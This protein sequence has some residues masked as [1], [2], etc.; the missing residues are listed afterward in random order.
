M[1]LRQR[2]EREIY[3]TEVEAYVFDEYYDIV[4]AGLG[5]AGCIA[6]I[7]AAKKGL[8]VLGIERLNCMGGQGTAGAVFSYYYGANG[9]LFEDIDNEVNEMEKL[10]YTKTHGINPFLKKYILEK[11]ALN[12][13]VTISYESVVTGVYLEGKKATG[14]KW[15]YDGRFI[16]TGAKVVIDSTA[17]ADI[18]DMAG[19]ETR[20]GREIDNGCQP[21]SNVMVTL[22]GNET[23]CRFIDEG[24]I[25]Q[26]DGDELSEAI[27][28]TMTHP[29][30]L[31]EYF[32]PIDR[33]LYYTEHLGVR[34]GRHIVG[35]ETVT[36]NDFLKDRVT[37][38]PLFFS[39]SN[40]DKH[41]CDFGFESDLI[42][43]W[44]IVGGLWEI[45]ISVPI[46]MGAIIPKGYDGI[47]AAARH[48]AVDHDIATAVRMKRDMHKCGEAAAIVAYASIYSNCRLKDVSYDFILPLLKENKCLSEENNFKRNEPVSK[49]G[50]VFKNIDR[51]SNKEELKQMLSCEK[52]GIA[53]WSCRRLGVT[54]SDE[55]KKWLESEDKNLSENSALA[56]GLIGD[57]AALPVLREIVSK[58]KTHTSEEFGKNRGIAAVF[59]LGKLC[60]ADSIQELI[61]ILDGFDIAQ[62]E[63]TKDSFLQYYIY[64][65]LALIKIGKHYHREKR[66]EISEAIFRSL[67]KADIDYSNT[68]E[69]KTQSFVDLIFKIKE[70]ALKLTTE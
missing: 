14:I 60:D 23:W 54:I 13:G 3:E 21:F 38:K 34:E 62:I 2:V 48:L 53:I 56:L 70:F 19:C 58:R 51:I 17:E 8:K 1:I 9:G 59:L 68:P 39:Y 28:E 25:N 18:C 64:A 4:I 27:I 16:N 45:N 63:D 6:A 46:P 42:Q 5:T 33:V 49:E 61:R 26:T 40:L 20:M 47:L 31:R 50:P 66:K 67:V 10:G 69:I 43:E 41:G 36:L 55:L 44:A 37:D 65:I 57:K 35:E 11:E 30:H 29:M 7:A 32:D 15:F 52:P 24:H 12:A 22:Y